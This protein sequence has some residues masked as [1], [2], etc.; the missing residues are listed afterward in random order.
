MIQQSIAENWI[1][2]QRFRLLLGEL[3]W[4]GVGPF[5]P[6]L[7]SLGIPVDQI[8]KFEP[9]TEMY[10]A[11]IR[12]DRN[13]W[14]LDP[15]GKEALLVPC[16]DEFE[17]AV[18]FVA[19]LLDGSPA[20]ALFN[21]IPVLGF[22]RLVRP[23]HPGRVAVHETPLDWLRNSCDGCFI[24][25]WGEAAETL[26]SQPVSFLVSSRAVARSLRKAGIPANRMIK[27]NV[28]RQERA[29]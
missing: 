22:D 11:R 27:A 7:R 5:L 4:R 23:Q 8:Q 2:F 1:T 15:A 20:F 26:S 10:M 19:V 17:E 24:L 6:K 13:E 18:D 16:I 3:Y 12:H 21:R 28:P 29:A 9:H 14:E 25:N